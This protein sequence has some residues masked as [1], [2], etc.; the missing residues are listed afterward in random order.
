MISMSKAYSIRRLRMEGDSIAE[1]SRKLEVSRDTV[2]RYLREEDLS[3]RPPAPRRRESVLDPY[4]PLIESWLDEDERSWRKQRHTAH[5]VWERLRDEAGARVAESTVRNYVRRLRL[6][7]GSRKGQYLDLEWAPG[8]AQADFGEADFYV[9]GVRT[10]LS[11]FVVEFPFSNV[12]LAQVFPGENAECVCQA[13]KNVFGFVGGVPTRIVFDNAAGVGRR[14]GDAVR[15]TGMF[16]AFAAHYGFA[17]S[18][19]NRN[20]GHEKG[21]VER[22]VGYVRDNLFVPVPHVTSPA[23]FNERLLE[24]SMAL[25]DKPHWAKGESELQLFVEDRFAMIGLPPTPFSVVRYEVRRAD[26]LGKVRVDGPHLCSSDPS[27]AGRELVCGIGATTVTVATR[28]GAVVAERPRA[29]GDAPTDT[30]DPASQLALLCGRP[31]AWANSKVRAAL[32]EALRGRMDSLPRA[33]LKAELRL[34]RDQ[35]AETG[36][37]ATVEAMA[38]ALAATGRVDRASVAVCAARILGGGVSY[39]EPVDLSEYDSAL[40]A[41]RGR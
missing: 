36:W 7:R 21:S 32:P 41:A 8:E 20:A 1:I 4:R 22:E 40:G 5:R 30:A 25:S 11:F 39:D 35:A 15:T 29:C 3:E 38:G 13:L 18:F 23:A 10:R 6:E 16:S 12:G 27:L 14:V 19:C 17:Y 26:R 31:G 9:G 24:R 28:D 2:Y 37:A 34:M 33:D